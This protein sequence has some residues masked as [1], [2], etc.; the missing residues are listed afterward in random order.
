MAVRAIQNHRLAY[1]CRYVRT[2]IRNRCIIRIEYIHAHRVHVA[3]Q[4]SVVN[5]PQAQHVLPGL[6]RNKTRVRIV[7]TRQRTIKTV[8]VT[9]KEPVVS[10]NLTV[11]VNTTAAI[12]RHCLAGLGLYIRP[13]VRN[14]RY[15]RATCRY[16]HL[17][18]GAVARPVVYHQ[19]NHVVTV[20]V[21]RELRVLRTGIVKVRC[22]PIRLAGHLPLV[23]QGVSVRVVRTVPAQ[24][25]NLA[26]GRIPRRSCNCHRRGLATVRIH[27]QFPRQ[28]GEFAV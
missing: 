9:D 21:R 8:R 7:R 27:R 23:R 14:W 26:R 10:R 22:A 4:P 19:R 25:H 18:G 17:R 2:R 1:A 3:H 15:L 13:G 20:N 12:Q 28:T 24:L 11:R 5:N 16:R 6:A